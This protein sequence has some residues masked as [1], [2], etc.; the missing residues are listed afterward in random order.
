MSVLVCNTSPLILL[1]KVGLLPLLPQLFDRV[2]VPGAV[3]AEIMAGPEGDPMAAALP[4][5]RW[6]ERVDLT[7]GLS[8]LARWQLGA[9]EA[10]VIEY[11]R[12]NGSLPVAIDDRAGRRAA[13]ALGL[14]LYGTLSIVAIAAKQGRIQSFDSAVA[15]LRA[16]GLYVSDQVVND[17]RR[18][19]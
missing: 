12:L 5:E 9:G 18:S 17:V 11:A 6:L 8:P 3:I 1:A 14:R 15:Q 2:L 13:L 7:P 16:S 4:N 19:L 10:E